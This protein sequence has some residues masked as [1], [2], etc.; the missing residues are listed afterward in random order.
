MIMIKTE[1]GWR[2]ISSVAV[3]HNDCEGVFRPAS[4]EEARAETMRRANDYQRDVQRYLR[5]EIQKEEIFRSFNV[6]IF[7]AFG[8]KL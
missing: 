7:G 3:N 2:P 5:G 8:E 4:Y 1:R 6:P